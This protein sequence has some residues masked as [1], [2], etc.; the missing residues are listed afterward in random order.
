MYTC[1]LLAVSAIYIVHVFLKKDYGQNIQ[2]QPTEFDTSQ[3]KHSSQA[4][5]IPSMANIQQLK[6]PSQ[7]GDIS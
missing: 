5:D 6:E 7:T 1:L 4:E 2:P 3:T